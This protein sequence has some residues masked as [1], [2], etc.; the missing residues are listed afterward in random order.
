MP[1]R[2]IGV[3]THNVTEALQAL[4]D[5]ADYIGTGA[6]YPTSTKDSTAIG[7][8]KF[9][10]VCDSCGIGPPR[11]LSQKAM[12]VRLVYLQVYHVLLLEAS[13]RRMPPK[14]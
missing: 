5:G 3:S 12:P 11:N 13:M 8:D 14:P 9:R 4:E 1:H 6:V 10:E 2:I 7:V